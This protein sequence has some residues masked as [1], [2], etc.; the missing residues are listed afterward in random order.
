MDATG[1]MKNC[2]HDQ[3]CSTDK[4]KSAYCPGLDEQAIKMMEGRS[5]LVHT[6]DI[7][8]EKPEWYDEEKFKKGQQM[9]E[10][11]YG[12]ILLAHLSSLIMLLFAPSV[13]K[14]LIFTGK[15]ETPKK[16]YRRYIATTV[17]VMSWYRGDIWREG[18]GARESLR[19]V[20]KYHSDGALTMN[21]EKMKP[22]VDR[23]D[24]SQCGPSLD[25]GKPFRHAMQ[26]DY[27][28]VI[29]CPFFD[30]GISTP[31]VVS[32]SPSA[33]LTYFNQADMSG[34][35]FAFIGLIVLYPQK[36]G[37]GRATDEEMEG[38]IHLWRCIGYMLGIEDRFNFCCHDN[39]RE[40]RAWASDFLD[41][42][43]K[44]MLKISITAEYEHMGRA[45]ALGAR[46]YLPLS[47]ETIYMHICWV[48]E[49]PI[50]NSRAY[51]FRDRFSFYQ[52]I[53]IFNW[54][55]NLWGGNIYINWFS[56]F[57]VQ[58]IVSPSSNWLSFK[59][60]VVPGLRELWNNP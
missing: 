48:T 59:P 19:Q 25:R 47:Y 33:N 11:Y 15:S 50:A 5:I 38:F 29:D 56:R 10:K 4:P 7:P 8:A 39:L 28:S 26:K 14:P 16:S 37:L 35:Q 60:P 46:S 30:S 43:V 6:G 22:I 20:R 17:H 23:V 57:V 41:F 49:L 44:P 21:S 13:L 42:F 53:F 34:T 24:I 45:V 31:D 55:G 2:N 18:S 27:S 58:Q 3:I 1:K 32:W 36:F 9:A 12:G 52:L 54:V 40:T 51:S